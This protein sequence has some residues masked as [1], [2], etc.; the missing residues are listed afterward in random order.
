MNDA[1]ARTSPAARSA[2]V[3]IEWMWALVGPAAFLAALAV[4]YRPQFDDAAG[5]L[6]ATVPWICIA[7]MMAAMSGLVAD[8]PMA[9]RVVG[10]IMTL[11]AWAVLMFDDDRW[12]IA[13]FSIY[14]V[15]YAAWGSRPLVAVG[16]SAVASAIWIAGWMA[17]DAPSWTA[18]IPLGVFGVGSAIAVSMH[19]AAV[20]NDE[21]AALIDQLRAARLE[22]AESE[23]S[24]G[25]LEER[26]R[27]AGEIHDTLA[28]GFT[29]IVLLS[30]AAQRSSAAEADLTT[31]TA[32]EATAQENLDASRRLIDAMRPPELETVSLQEALRRHVS[33]AER[34]PPAELRVVGT[35]RQLPGAVEVTILR[36]AQELTANAAEHARA[37]HVDVTLSYLDD[38]VALDVA[39][40][41]VGFTPGTVADRDT[42]TG[43]QGLDALA[44]RVESLAGRFTIE[45]ADQQGSVLSVIIPAGGR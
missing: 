18:V 44:R 2:A 22:L 5:V 1:A 45:T 11:G 42:L 40:D 3:P 12:S 26:A 35:P 27:M 31:L 43:G 37:D 41:G 24:K 17:A 21:Q 38:A 8:S 39:D 20:L 13:S 32:I 15:C 30:R 25:V 14:T 36:A 33:S 16:L 6:M 10:T 7:G 29:S 4:A 23:R 19:R 9:V 34:R 28:Q